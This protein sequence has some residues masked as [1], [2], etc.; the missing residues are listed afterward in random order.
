LCKSKHNA[1]DITELKKLRE[2]VCKIIILL[3]VRNG[4]VTGYPLT[5]ENETADSRKEGR[6]EGV[7]L[8]LK[9]EGG[10]TF[11]SP[12]LTTSNPQ[13]SFNMKE[14]KKTKYNTKYIKADVFFKLKRWHK[15]KKK[16]FAIYGYTCMKCGANNCE[17]HIDHI[18]S[19]ML[20]PDLQFTL[21]NLQVLCRQCNIDK[22]WHGKKD[23]RPIKAS[24][25]QDT[26]SEHWNRLQ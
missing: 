17:L 9:G 7:T 5:A 22:S 8:L 11:R 25:L 26:I 23:Y 13:G 15:L 19:R 24:Y 20:R 16:V 18:K 2:Q 1:N 4:S 6:W 10:N 14:Q 3:N 12:F 21:N